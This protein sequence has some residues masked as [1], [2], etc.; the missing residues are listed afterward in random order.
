MRR[1]LAIVLAAVLVAGTMILPTLHMFQCDGHDG[2]DSSHCPLCQLVN[3][4]LHDAEPQVG[5]VVV[6]VSGVFHSI[7]PRLVFAAVPGGSAQARAPPVA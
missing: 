2:H 7:P 5:P 6:F 4:P 1:T 3:A